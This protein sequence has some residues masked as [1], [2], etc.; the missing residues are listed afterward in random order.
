MQEK[1]NIEKA[2]ESEI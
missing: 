1:V 2:K